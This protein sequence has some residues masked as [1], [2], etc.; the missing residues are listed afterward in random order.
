MT[1]PDAKA[2]MRM[3]KL[4]ALARRGVDG[5]AET[6]ER[7]L[8]TML[9]RH[10]T[11]IDEIGN[12]EQRRTR[13]ARKYLTRVERKLLTQILATRAALEAL[14][15][16]A[17]LTLLYAEIEGHRPTTNPRWKP[18]VRSKVQRLA[19]RVGAGEWALTESIAA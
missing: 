9:A 1:T 2:L 11:T 14:G 18:K 12:P 4:L 7:F 17:T 5:Q 6:A 13:A 16:R 8:A 15:G 19:V 10:G 3:R